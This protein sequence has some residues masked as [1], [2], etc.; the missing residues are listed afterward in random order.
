LAK[1]FPKSNSKKV[2]KKTRDYLFE[3]IWSALECLD[4]DL[5]SDRADVLDTEQ[6]VTLSYLLCG[7]SDF[8]RGSIP[9]PPAAN[10]KKK[11]R[12]KPRPKARLK[13]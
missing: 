11:A 2:S 10:V 3:I 4:N 6:L 13:G 5:T 9:P 8:V 12:K 1:K 7:V